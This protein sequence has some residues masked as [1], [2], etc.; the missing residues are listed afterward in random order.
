M[1]GKAEWIACDANEPVPPRQHRGSR[2]LFASRMGAGGSAAA[3]GQPGCVYALQHA[4]RRVA[5][6]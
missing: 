1:R 5:D 3:D 2:E 6:I 4:A